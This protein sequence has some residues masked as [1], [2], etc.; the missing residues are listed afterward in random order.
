M[1]QRG[2]WLKPNPPSGDCH[3][4]CPYRAETSSSSELLS[5]VTRAF[6]LRP[7]PPVLLTGTQILLEL[8]GQQ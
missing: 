4:Q 8:A 5:R 1:M 6:F 2:I 3:H 7:E